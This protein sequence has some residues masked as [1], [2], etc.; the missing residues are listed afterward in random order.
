MGEQVIF[1]IVGRILIA[2]YRQ[3]VE[4]VIAVGNVYGMRTHLVAEANG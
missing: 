4:E 2:A 3:V 1:A